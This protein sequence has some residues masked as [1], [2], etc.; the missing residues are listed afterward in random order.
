MKP[1]FEELVRK[2]GFCGYNFT[3]TQ[4]GTYQ[5]TALE[6]LIELV[7][8]EA[9]DSIRHDDVMNGGKLQRT[10]KTHFGVE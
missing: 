2:A 8:Q 10:I 7:V 5:E 1:K 3:N 9:C 4:V 6:Y